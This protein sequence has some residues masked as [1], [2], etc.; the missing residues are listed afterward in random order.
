MARLKC[1]GTSGGEPC[2][3]AQRV[4][5]ISPRWLLFLLSLCRGWGLFCPHLQPD[6]GWQCGAGVHLSLWGEGYMRKVYPCLRVGVPE[7]VSGRRVAAAERSDLSLEKEM[8]LACLV[9]GPL[10]GWDRAPLLSPSPGR[11]LQLAS[12]E[13]SPGPSF[14]WSSRPLCPLSGP[15]GSVSLLQSTASPPASLLSTLAVGTKPITERR[16][17]NWHMG[18]EAFS[19]QANNLCLLTKGDH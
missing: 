5:V 4:Q 6:K 19:D 8:N 10:I 11:R 12:S 13:R 16:G 18:K 2:K 7:L 17:W 1:W 3:L 9:P 14:R 15:G